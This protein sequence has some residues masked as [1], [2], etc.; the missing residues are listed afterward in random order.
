VNLLIFLKLIHTL[1]YL[2]KEC[3]GS[4]TLGGTKKYLSPECI[5]NGNK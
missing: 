3:D 4:E 1:K 5:V 2:Y